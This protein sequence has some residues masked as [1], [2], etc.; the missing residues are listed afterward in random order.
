MAQ[1][2]STS[3]DERGRS[4]AHLVS[5]DASSPS[6]SALL[7]QSQVVADARARLEAVQPC[8]ELTTIDDE[9]REV[10][11]RVHAATACRRD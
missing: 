9:S 3:F 6:D 1:E 8:Q 11:G 10:L 4:R 5:D 2:V 7:R